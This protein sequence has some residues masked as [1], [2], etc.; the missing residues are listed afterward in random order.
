V[1]IGL[2]TSIPFV[3]LSFNIDRV[4]AWSKIQLIRLNRR[5]ESFDGINLGIFGSGILLSAI[6]VL[7][8]AVVII[9]VIWTSPL[10]STIKLAVTIAIVLLVVVAIT[11]FGIH[12]L[13]QRVGRSKRD[14]ERDTETE[15][16]D[17]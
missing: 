2:A 13:Q 11:F 5:W 15:I 3:F 14:T 12:Y 8:L 17:T 10:V 9:V 4:S 1:G 7:L 6:G 16:S